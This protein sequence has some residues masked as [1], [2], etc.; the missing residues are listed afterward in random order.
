MSPFRHHGGPVVDAC[1]EAGCDYLDI[2]G[3]SE[4]MERMVAIYHQ[5]ALENGT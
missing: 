2:C 3:E 5:R 4:F 1:V